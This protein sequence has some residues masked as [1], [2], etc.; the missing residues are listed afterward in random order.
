MATAVPPPIPPAQITICGTLSDETIAALVGVAMRAGAAL[1]VQPRLAAADVVEA[2][3]APPKRLPPARAA[4]SV[5]TAAPVGRLRGLAP[6]DDELR[7]RVA[8]VLMGGS[9]LVAEFLQRA[10]VDKLTG[11]EL[12]RQGI[13]IATGATVNRR[14]ALPGKPAKEAP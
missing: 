11:R 5:R 2:S 13:V 7:N 4:K 14:Y 9:M 12:V 1:M 3:P 8:K 10:K 6:I